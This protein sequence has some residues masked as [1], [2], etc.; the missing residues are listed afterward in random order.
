MA[1]YETAQHMHRIAA[2]VVI[3]KLALQEKPS[4]CFLNPKARYWKRS[5][6]HDRPLNSAFPAKPS[7]QSCTANRFIVDMYRQGELCLYNSKLDARD[8]LALN[9]LSPM[10]RRSIAFIIPLGWFVSWTDVLDAFLCVV[11]SSPRR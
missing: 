8:T 7:P 9:K 10:G 3:L 5:H 1:V 6:Q 4:I 11:H 2:A